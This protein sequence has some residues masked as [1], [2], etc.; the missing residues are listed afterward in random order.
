MEK[1]I[2]TI[3]NILSTA[4]VAVVVVL[5]VLLAGVRLVGL[6]PYTVLSG[7]MEPT[8][9]VGSVIYVKNVAPATLEVGSPVTFRLNDGIIATHRIVEISGEG[10]ALSF[11]TKGD[12]NETDDGKPIPASAV[13]GMPV[14]SVPYLGFISAF[15][16]T[17][18]GL[19]IVVAS[20]ITVLLCSFIIESLL[21]EK[22][23]A[24]EDEALPET[25]ESF[26]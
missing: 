5:A 24:E 16:Q 18:K 8:Y 10:Q 12:A 22:K 26:R 14:F 23:K 13:I 17:P 21:P 1:I 9:S 15:I 6:T 7:S 11:L 20:A 19:M 25:E 2:R 4:I 3:I